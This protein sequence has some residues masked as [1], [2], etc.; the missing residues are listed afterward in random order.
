MPKRIEPNVVRD[1]EKHD[2]LYVPDPKVKQINANRKEKG[3]TPSLLA[4]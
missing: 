2:K 1:Q 3:T 4:I